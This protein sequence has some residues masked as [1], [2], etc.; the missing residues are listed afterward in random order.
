M[1]TGCRASHNC[2]SSLSDQN[3]RRKTTRPPPS[4]PAPRVR[5]KVWRSSTTPTASCTTS[6]GGPPTTGTQTLSWRRTVA[7]QSLRT[8]QGSRAG[9]GDG[10]GGDAIRSTAGCDVLHQGG[11]GEGP[12]QTDEIL[13]GRCGGGGQVPEERDEELQADQGL[14]TGPGCGRLLRQSV[15]LC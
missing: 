3:C 4:R 15:L 2:T 10:G 1:G 7:S 11:G 13:P 6:T 9:R 14:G 12:G 8:T 5:T